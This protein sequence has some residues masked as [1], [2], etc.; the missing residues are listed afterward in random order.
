MVIALGIKGR[1]WAWRHC[2]WDSVEHFKRVQ[3]KWSIAGFIFLA[4]SIIFVF[5]SHLL[6]RNQASSSKQQFFAV[7]GSYM[8]AI[9][10]INHN[11][12]NI[13]RQDQGH[14]FEAITAS[15]G[16]N[17]EYID[18]VQTPYGAFEKACFIH[19]PTKNHI[20]SCEMLYNASKAKSSACKMATKKV[21]HRHQ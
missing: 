20:P 11:A 12:Q 8:T 3:K 19:A 15:L 18:T 17:Q 16:L 2:D 21:Y 4:G 6:M 14:P 1:E 10:K 9:N 7:C 13:Q 5:G